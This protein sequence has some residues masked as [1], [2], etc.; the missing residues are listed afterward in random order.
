M[1]FSGEF[2]A[3]YTVNGEKRRRPW[4][5][6]LVETLCENPAEEGAGHHVLPVQILNDDLCLGLTTRPVNSEPRDRIPPFPAHA[7]MFKTIVLVTLHPL[8]KATE[9]FL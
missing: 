4:Q 2:S 9:T 6:S 5:R 3:V 8:S 7:C 1:W